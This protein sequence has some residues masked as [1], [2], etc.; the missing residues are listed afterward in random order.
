MRYLASLANYVLLLQ[1]FLP[2]CF[3]KLRKWSYR[4]WHFVLIILR[5]SG[6]LP[7]ALDFKIQHI[8]GVRGQAF[9]KFRSSKGVISSPLVFGFQKT[10]YQVGQVACPLKLK[11]F[12]NLDLQKGWFLALQSLDFKRQHIKGVRGLAPWSSS[13]F[14]IRIFKRANF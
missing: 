8:K 5:G 2:P 13:I 3:A 7:S 1:F 11:Q 4:R 6:G 12:L 9:S 14:K 10:A